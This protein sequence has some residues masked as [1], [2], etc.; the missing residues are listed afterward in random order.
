MESRELE[1]GTSIRRRRECLE[2]RS[3]FTTYERIE[4]PPLTVVKK[5]GRRQPFN[6]Q[7]ITSGLYRACEKRPISADQI[8]SLT[9]EIEAAARALGNPEIPVAAMGEIVMDKLRTFDDVAYV[10]FAS[11]YRAFTDIDSFQRE[12]D[13]LSKRPPRP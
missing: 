1:D 7:K 11:V 2:C 9:N 5:D 12:L 3:R 10:R 4:R 8:E 13:R 6:R